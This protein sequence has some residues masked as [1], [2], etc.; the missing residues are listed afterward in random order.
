MWHG[1]KGAH[2]SLLAQNMIDRSCVC[3]SAFSSFRSTLAASLAAHPLPGLAAGAGA[4]AGA[5]GGGGGP[6]PL[7]PPFPPRG[8]AFTT[9]DIPDTIQETGGEGSVAGGSL[10]A[11]EEGQEE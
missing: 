9:P 6:N 7:A 2:P 10:S 1:N 11:H 3:S 4:G 5:G 8:Q